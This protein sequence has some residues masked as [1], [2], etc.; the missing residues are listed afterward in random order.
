MAKD[1]ILAIRGGRFDFLL[2]KLGSEADRDNLF[3]AAIILNARIIYGDPKRWHGSVNDFNDS[4]CQYDFL[5]SHWQ[6]FSDFLD[7]LPCQLSGT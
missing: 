4:G 2:S 5:G 1:I 3:V 6:L 7:K